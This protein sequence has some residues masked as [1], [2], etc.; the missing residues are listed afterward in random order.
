M[1]DWDKMQDSR[2]TIF[3][4]IPS[5]LDPSL[6]PEGASVVLLQWLSA[7]LPFSKLNNFIFGYFHPENIFL[8]NENN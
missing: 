1:E 8:D 6:A 4:S 3:V 2:G 7:V 5:L